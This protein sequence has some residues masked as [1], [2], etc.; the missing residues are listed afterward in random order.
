MVPTPGVTGNP[1]IE[2]ERE[3]SQ[4]RV[5]TPE[6]KL[7]K[8]TKKKKYTGVV[9]GVMKMSNIYRTNLAVAQKTSRKR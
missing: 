8:Q 7:K 3:K 9:S 2:T 5:K 1:G 4:S 6:S